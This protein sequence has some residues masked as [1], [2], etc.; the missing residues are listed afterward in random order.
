MCTRGV[1]L[2]YPGKNLIEAET[3]EPAFGCAPAIISIRTKTMDVNEVIGRL[4]AKHNRNIV[5]I[6]L[7]LLNIVAL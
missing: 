1:F 6:M 7:A 2:A 5:L 3:L 4:A